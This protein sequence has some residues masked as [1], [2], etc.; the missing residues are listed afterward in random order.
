[1]PPPLSLD[2]T[3]VRLLAASARSA[4]SAARSC[5]ART[6]GRRSAR[7]CAHRSRSWASAA[8][9]AVDTVPS[10]PGDAAVGPHLDAVACSARPARRRAPGWTRRAPAGRR[11]AARRRPRRRRAGRWSAGARRAGRAPPRQRVPLASAQRRSQA[12]IG[13]RRWSPRGCRWPASCPTRRASAGRW[14][15]RTPAPTGSASS[16][17]TGRC[18]VGRPSMM[19]CC[20]RSS[21]SASGCSGLAGG[22]AVGSA[23]VGSAARLGCTPAPWPAMTT[24]S[25]VRSMSSG[26]SNVTGGV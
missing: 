14:S 17:D 24:V 11:R 5:R 12:G 6:S 23:T 18:S 13:R 1:M 16:A 20:G 4:R 2:T 10:M 19:T 3:M 26:W 7:R 9:I 8:P 21:G 25:G 15:A 22:G